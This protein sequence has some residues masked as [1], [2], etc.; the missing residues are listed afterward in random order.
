[1][2]KKAPTPTPQSEP[3]AEQKPSCTT[4]EPA[5][6]L[7]VLCD[8]AWRIAQARNALPVVAIS[9]DVLSSAMSLEWQAA[10]KQAYALIQVADLHRKEA[11]ASAQIS[12]H[13]QNAVDTIRSKM[14]PMELEKGVVPFGRGCRLITGID[15][16]KTAVELFHRAIDR[17]YMPISPR[18]LREFEAD[19]FFFDDMPELRAAFLRARPF[20]RANGAKTTG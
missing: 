1:M 18:M 15:K 8:M 11:H 10:V 19:G 7:D 14:M 5:V 13:V 16:K 12:P 9:R 6:P 2:N 4:D 3:Q 20:L 17:G